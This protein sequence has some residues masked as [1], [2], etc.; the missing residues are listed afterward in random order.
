MKTNLKKK[1][2]EIKPVGIYLKLFDRKYCN[3]SVEKEVLI[4]TIRK[5]IR[6]FGI[7]DW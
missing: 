1:N 3:L 2:R 7:R 4:N 6:R 5:K